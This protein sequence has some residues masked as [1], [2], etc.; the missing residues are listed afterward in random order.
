MPPSALPRGPPQGKTGPLPGSK[1]MDML[2]LK[3]L[4][5]AMRSAGLDALLLTNPKNV[6]YITG[7]APMMEGSVMPFHDPEYFALIQSDRC[8]VLCD[9]RYI[10]EIQGRSGFTTNLLEAP[11]NAA[12]LGD[13]IRPLL[14]PGARTIGYESDA[15]LHRDAVALM[16]YLPVYTWKAAEQLPSDMRVIKSRAEIELIGR[17]QAITGDA[18]GHVCKTIRVGMTK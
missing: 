2:R 8:D 7:I 14:M 4:Q 16:G 1:T 10:G 6:L 5:D 3:R 9:G 11:V 12:V 13:K 17:A 15:M 18:F